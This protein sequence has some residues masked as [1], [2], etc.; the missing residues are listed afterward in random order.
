MAFLDIS[1]SIRNYASSQ[2]DINEN[3]Y[4]VKVLNFYLNF[5]F[6]I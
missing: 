2:G 3:L 4:E 6:L 1:S 5:V